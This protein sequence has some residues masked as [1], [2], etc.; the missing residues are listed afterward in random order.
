[1]FFLDNDGDKDLVIFFNDGSSPV[2]VY[3]DDG[4]CFGQKHVRNV[5]APTC[6]ECVG[7]NLAI[8]FK[9]KI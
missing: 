2:I 6:T 1:M 9:K 8:F 4:N 3:N 7:G 5:P